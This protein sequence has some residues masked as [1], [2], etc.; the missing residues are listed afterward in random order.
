MTLKSQSIDAVTSAICVGLKGEFSVKENAEASVDRLSLKKRLFFTLLVSVIGLALAL[1]VAEIVVRQTRAP[2]PT[3]ETVKNRTL[4]YAPSLF[5]RHV[6]PPKALRA[7]NEDEV[8]PVEYYINDK[9][10]RGRN[11]S[12]RKP[13]GTIRIIFY[14]GSATFDVN[15]P[16]GQDWPHRVEAILQQSGYPQVEIINAGTPG[17]ASWDS[18]GKL[19]S[20]GHHFD[21]DYVVSN[22]GW[23]DFRYFLTN[24][25]LLRQFQP[26][27]RTSRETDPRLNYQN[28]L[29]RVLCENSQLYLRLRARYADWKLGIGRLGATTK[30]HYSSDITETAIKQYYLNQ[31]MFVEMARAIGATPVLMIEARLTAPNNTDSQKARIEPYMAYVK[32]D[33]YG[34]LKAYDGIE[35]TIRKISLEKNVALIDASNELNGRDEMF[36]DVAHLTPRGSEEL[37][38]LTARRLLDLLK[39][40][41]Y[42]K[43]FR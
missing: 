7:S 34:L 8:N 25:S 2:Y 31:V 5:A 10:Y 12:T 3:P 30:G 26:L 24:E 18:L 41:N 27:C 20:E 1:V 42:G 16:E 11:F 36:S 28:R 35:R 32:M 19:L 38:Q 23:N 6:F 33:H 29:D 9:G 21:P 13:E 40:R 39:N 15:L 14:G 4:E 17:H 22:N 37:A 43:M